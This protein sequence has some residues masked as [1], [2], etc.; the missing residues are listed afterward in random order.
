MSKRAIIRD[1]QEERRKAYKKLET[2]G[3]SPEAIWEAL[4]L[5]QTRGLDIGPKA[6]KILEKR[7]Q[8][9]K[10]IPK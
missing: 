10:N 5:L 1:A 8:I 4:H 6:S 7:S 2:S 3:E 9:K